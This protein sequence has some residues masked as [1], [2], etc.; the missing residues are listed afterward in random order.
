MIW[1]RLIGKIFRIL[2]AEATPKQIAGGV[3]LGMIIG[4]TP[5]FSLHNIVVVFLIL[6][7][8]VNL[9]AAILSMFAFDLIGYGVDPISDWVGYAILTSDTL[10]PLWIEAY[11][12]AIIP[13]TRFNNTIVMGSLVISLILLYPIFRLAKYGVERYRSDLAATFQQWRI[14]RA[15]KMSRFYRY[16]Q[17]FMGITG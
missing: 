10:R 11:N 16:Y 15:A 2:S 17:T 7:I 6:V 13:F 14:V 8:K 1:L 12:A 5:T 4:L 3:I 9:T